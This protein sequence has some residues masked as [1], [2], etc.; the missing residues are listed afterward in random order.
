MN[1]ERVIRAFLRGEQSKTPLREIQNGYYTYKGRTLWTN[2]NI[3]VNYSTNMAKL[4]VENNIVYVNKNKYSRTT[5][6]IQ[7][8][9]KSLAN[10]YDYKVI[11]VEPK[12]L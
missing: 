2:G 10:Q 9:I 6:K 1:N 5:S 4:D 8:Q 11:E 7:T 3:L 12:E